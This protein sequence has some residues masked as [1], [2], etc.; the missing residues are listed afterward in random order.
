MLEAASFFDLTEFNHKKIF[1]ETDSVWNGLINL[2][3]YMD[4]LDYSSFKHENLLDGTPLKKH[5][6]Y[7]QNSLQ[8]GEGCTISWDDVGKGKLSVMRAGQTLPGASVIMAGP[9]SWGINFSWAKGSD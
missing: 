6:L 2:K 7:Y 9:S 4:S 5:L 8:S 1:Q 3:P